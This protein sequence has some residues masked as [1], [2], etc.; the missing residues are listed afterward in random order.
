MA[1]ALYTNTTGLDAGQTDE[2]PAA[3][4]V[5]SSWGA[6]DVVGSDQ[7]IPVQVRNGRFLVHL[8][9]DGQTAL[10]DSVFDQRPLS[11]VA[12]VVNDSGEF[13]LPAQVLEKVP[14]AV[15]AQRANNFDV[16]GSLTVKQDAT[17][18]GE[19]NVHGN[20]VI[21]NGADRRGLTIDTPS[22]G[23]NWTSQGTYVQIGE[24][25]AEGG[26]AKM[27]MTYLGNGKGYTGAGRTDTAVPSGG[28][29]E[30][31]YNSRNVYTS[32]NVR[33]AANLVADSFNLGICVQ[34]QY[35]NWDGTFVQQPQI[36]ARLGDWTG[37]AGDGSNTTGGSDNNL[38]CR[39]RLYKY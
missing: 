5:W 19:L 17:I 18:Q 39:Y 29:W 12:W 7:T 30:Y 11:V 34:C 4:R 9:E 1:F 26:S 37:Y 27:N 35:Y 6:G 23:D 10:A 22:T 33:I 25:T 2:V 28:F 32:S 31:T 21:G 14:H 13:R 8:G 24:G 3:N 38:R 20:L 16:E 36:C 15:T